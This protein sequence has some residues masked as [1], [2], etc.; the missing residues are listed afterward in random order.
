M[1]SHVILL[2]F[3]PTRAGGS[4]PNHEGTRL[5]K[6]ARPR[7]E[8]AALKTKPAL[9]LQDVF[10]PLLKLPIREAIRANCG[11]MLQY[12]NPSHTGN[13]HTYLALLV[14]W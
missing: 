12:K 9:M 1:L 7:R 2:V 3:L 10:N 14:P 8:G 6:G 4:A 5:A 11:C 13:L